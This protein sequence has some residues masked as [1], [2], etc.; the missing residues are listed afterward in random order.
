MAPGLHL[1]LHLAYIQK[2]KKKSIE[3]QQKDT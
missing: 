2:N 1:S 3:S